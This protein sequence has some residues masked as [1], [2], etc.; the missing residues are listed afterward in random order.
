MN[1]INKIINSPKTLLCE[2]YWLKKTNKPYKH[3]PQEKV[4]TSFDLHEINFFLLNDSL[5]NTISTFDSSE[6]TLGIQNMISLTDE[7]FKQLTPTKTPMTLW[8]GI[9]PFKEFIK[10]FEKSL[11]IKKGDIIHMPEYAYASYT[12]TCAKNYAQRL[13]KKGILFEITVPKNSKISRGV[14]CIFP[15][16]S[17]FECTETIEKDRYKLIKLNYLP[18]KNLNNNNFMKTLSSLF[19]KLRI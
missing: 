17:V 8:R 11:Q 2:E 18:P 6:T 3:N 1:M 16:A 4:S 19:K 10:R 5:F 12:K 7:E 9:T 13:N 14:H 15:R